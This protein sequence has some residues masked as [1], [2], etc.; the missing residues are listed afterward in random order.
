MAVAQFARRFPPNKANGVKSFMFMVS[1]CR[2]LH[3]RPPVPG[4]DWGSRFGSG[5]FLDEQRQFWIRPVESMDLQSS[6]TGLA[7]GGSLGVEVGGASASCRA[8][9]LNEQSQF[10]VNHLKSMDFR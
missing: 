2:L 4:R 10:S 5:G 6:G 9:F 8:S 7:A 1:A 3:V